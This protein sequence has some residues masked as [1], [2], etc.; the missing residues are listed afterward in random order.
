MQ[1]ESY[2][3]ADNRAPCDFHRVGHDGRA[4][5]IRDVGVA[6]ATPAPSGYS[7]ADQIVLPYAG[8][9]AYRVGSRTTL[10]DA[11]TILFAVA[12]EEFRDSHVVRGVGHASVI[13]EPMPAL[14]DEVFADAAARRRMFDGGSAPAS[15]RTQWLTHRLRH[16]FGRGNPLEIEELTIAVLRDIAGACRSRLSAPV[17]ARAKEFLHA[18]SDRHPSLVEVAE[19]VGVS[20]CY[21]SHA[22]AVAEGQPLYRYQ[23]GL[24]LARALA[25]LPDCDDLTP[26]ALDLGFSSHAHFSTAFKSAYGVTPSLARRLSRSVR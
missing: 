6:F 24:R 17:V 12:G 10:Y 23:L 26:L 11:N 15:R 22:F 19:A 7:A 18:Q 2:F 8:V 9:F 14:F 3:A 1:A 20:A 5:R 25:A 21:L 13:V 16:S 4:G